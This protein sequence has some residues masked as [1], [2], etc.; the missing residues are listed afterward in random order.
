MY[1]AFQYKSSS[2]LKGYPFAGKFNDYLGGGYV[3]EMRGKL[4]FLIGNFTELQKMSW[5]DD[6]TRAIF[7]E[8]SVFNPYLNILSV[9]TIL[10][11]ILAGGNLLTIGR[12]E[13]ITLFEESE[14]YYTIKICC[15]AIYMLFIIISMLKEIRR[16][17]KTGK[18]YFCEFWSITEWILIKFS[19]TTFI[20]YLYLYIQSKEVRSFF[21]K[22]SGYAYI[23]LQYISYVHESY[24]FC[25][26]FCVSICTLKL[27]RI[28]RF[29]PTISLLIS[30]IKSSAIELIS[31]GFL[32]LMAWFA[33]IQIFYII[34]FD[35]ILGFS[36][37]VRS[38]ETCFN[39]ML[40]KFQFSPLLKANTIFGPLI[41]GFYNLIMVFMLLN[42]FIS[43][44]GRTYLIVKNDSN[45]HFAENDILFYM[46]NRL[47]RMLFG[48]SKR[49]RLNENMNRK[50]RQA[51]NESFM[52]NIILFP[53]KLDH[54]TYLVTEVIILENL[55]S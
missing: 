48:S 28:L 25:M 43:I 27:L 30:T 54:L 44:I 32:F 4:E 24:T 15:S 11:E 20:M 10:I 17:I 49:N 47:W 9:N 12:F 50:E 16:A 19:L 1:N 53:E 39:I 13:P 6:Q 40:G 29:N 3:Y 35:K 5:I 51:N 46:K 22:T 8:F 38:M 34:F 2:I 7:V 52:D 45:K 33:F 21:S 14:S 41:F 55:I 42:I 36:T 18:R 37:M 23:K 31:F 26:A